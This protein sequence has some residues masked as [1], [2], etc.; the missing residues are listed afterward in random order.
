MKIKSFLF[1]G[2]IACLTLITAFTLQDDPFATLLKKAEEYV[3]QY[4][5][6]KVHL[7]LDKPYYAI[8]DNIWFK[9]YVLDT[10]TSTPS[11]ISSALYVEL[12][13]EKDSIKSQ[14]K[15]PL[16]YGIGWGDFKLPDTLNEGNYRIRAYT[17]W[18]RNAG[19][20]FFFDKTIK[21]GNSWANRVFTSTDY[22]FSKDNNTQNIAAKIKFTDPQGKPYPNQSVSY[23]AQ[24]NY[25][26]VAKGKGETDAEGVLTLNFANTQP[27]I[28]NSGKI[29]A[30]L[31]LPDK[32]KVIKTIPLKATSNDVEV[33]FF[34]E[35]GHLVENL[36]TKIGIKA[37]SANGLGK[38]VEGSIVDEK[39]NE[40]TKFTTTYL[41]MGN[42]V[43]SPQS[44][45]TYAAKVRF[46]DGSEKTYPLPRTLPSGYALSVSNS[47]PENVVVKIM[48][49]ESLLN[50]GELKL[51]AQ[52]N[53]S[54]YMNS[55]AGTAKQLITASIPKKDLPSG[56]IQLTLFSPE[57][58]PV[59]ERLVF[60]NNVNDKIA[61]SL[62]TPKQSYAKREKVDIDV[63][64]MANEKPVQGSFSVSVTNT[65]AINPDPE[66]ESNIFT[67]LLLTSDLI[68]YVEN[69][70]SYFLDEDAET[71]NRLDNLLLTQGWRRII[72]NNIIK[73]LKPNITYPPEKSLKI[74]GIITRG[75]GKPV[76]KA[77]VSLFSSSGGV[78]MIDTVADENGRFNFDQLTF[79]DST[80]FVVQGRTGA[81]KKFVE[82]ELD[83]VPGQIVTKN[84]N[85]GDI[86]V[87][88]NEAIQS[89]L[90]KS[91]NFF[92]EQVKRGALE[93]TINL[94]EVN[95]VQEKKIAK[96]S[97]NL[98]GAG[99]ADFVLTAD[100]MGTCITIE[101]CLQGRVAG[102]FF[103][104]GL[105]Y[106]SRNTG[107]GPMQ[108]I[109]D[110]M[111]MES[112]F[113]RNIV[114]FDVETIEVLKS[115]GNTAIYG[116]RGGGG[117]LI[118]TTK[119]GGSGGSYNSYAPGI[120]TTL[121]KGYYVSREFYS[122]KYETES[123]NANADLRSTV[124]WNPQVVTD[125]NG[126]GKFTFYNTDEPGEY[127]VVLEGLDALG[128]LARTVFTYQVN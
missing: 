106:L 62:S 84:P 31:T 44:G 81:D 87:N 40:I 68:G 79:A 60:V 77:K 8:G 108:L 117:V 101:Q 45:I 69:P 10:R 34:P 72:W 65:A 83:V 93:R 13:N 105:P 30:T 7:H 76:P 82:I 90:T 51:I 5:Q 53:G 1:A 126:K 38:N 64:A 33:Q 78:F 66:N 112:D 43:L 75:S 95:I 49:S 52:H 109:V 42:F 61:A 102:L 25:R 4:P 56:I 120:V 110:G 39:G 6:E 47:N 97:S 80:K 54:V 71:L 88:V 17:Q 74:S 11:N 18:M 119:R 104:D 2:C 57:N 125:V 63:T 96:N 98:N 24:L 107:G 29:I 3:K 122:P 85:T 20:E 35:G 32:R 103:R 116:S 9:A 48:I 121:P 123:G 27:S 15:I 50:K 22:T 127:R 21:I 14:L 92:E 89:Y 46:E 59:S 99:N 115:G 70:N 67:S 28:Y 12:I 91:Q 94:N 55:K 19:H 111:F 26:S 16:S 128:H 23:E 41:G 73:D 58:L 36:P 113:I 100:K 86:E 37:I 114:P 124:F 118:I